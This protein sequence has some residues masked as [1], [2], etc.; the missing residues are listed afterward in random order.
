[1]GGIHT[2]YVAQL[3]RAQGRSFM[4]L[5]PMI[6]QIEEDPLYEKRLQETANILAQ[7]IRPPSRQ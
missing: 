4:V 1:M 7:A 2:A 5:S 6:G 3:L